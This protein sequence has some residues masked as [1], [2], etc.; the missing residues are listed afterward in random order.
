MRILTWNIQSAQ[1]CDGRFDPTR[2]VE[3]VRRLGDWDVICFQEVARFF[4]EYG[5]EDQVACFAAAFADHE[6][7]WAPGVSWRGGGGRREFGNLTLV[8]TP[9]LLDQ[10]VHTLPCPPSPDALQAPRTVMETLIDAGSEPLLTL[11]THLAFHSRAEREAQ[12]RVL[13]RLK[14]HALRRAAEPGVAAD[15]GYFRRRPS[16]RHVLA[17]GDMNLVA[18]GDEYLRLIETDRWTDCWTARHGARPHAPTCGVYD[19]RLWPQGPHCRDFF[20]SGPSLAETVADVAADQSTEASDHQPVML[21]L[22][23]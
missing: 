1:G 18:G 21:T 4:D 3:T 14:D 17:C 20:L 9:L 23:L 13:T 22:A 15:T 5:G 2:I 11:N 7:A 16:A 12:C 10:R 6:T 8:R 19:T